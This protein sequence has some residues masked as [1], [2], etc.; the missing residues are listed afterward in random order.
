[1]VEMYDRGNIVL[2]DKDYRVVQ[3]VRGVVFDDDH[4]VAVGYIYP[5]AR[6][7]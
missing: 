5:K 6:I 1:M 7:V 4:R 2:V 3:M